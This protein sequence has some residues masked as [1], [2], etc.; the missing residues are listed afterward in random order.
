MRKPSKIFGSNPVDWGKSM[1]KLLSLNFD[2]FAE[3]HFGVY[4]PKNR[5]KEYIKNYL[6]HYGQI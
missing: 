2:V 3:G 1:K 5:A 4:K 6:T